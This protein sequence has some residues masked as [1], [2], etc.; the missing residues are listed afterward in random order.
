MQTAVPSRGPTATSLFPDEA[1]IAQLI[2]GAKRASAWSG[3]AVIL[4]RHGLPQIDP[5]LGGRY[6]PAVIS[7]FDRRYGVVG[8]LHAGYV[9]DGP[10]NWDEP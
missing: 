1:E 6:W 3:L 10:E 9:P 7:F 5:L 4:E 2:L 8:P